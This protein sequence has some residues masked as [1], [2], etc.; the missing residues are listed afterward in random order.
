MRPT[1]HITATGKGFLTLLLGLLAALGVIWAF[2]GIA[3][4]LGVGIALIAATRLL[5]TLLRP[6]ESE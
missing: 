1:L 4:A 6:H 5:I 3:P 2:Y